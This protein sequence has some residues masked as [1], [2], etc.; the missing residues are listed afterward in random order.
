MSELSCRSGVS[1]TSLGL[2]RSEWL[3]DLFP[4]LGCP[5]TISHGTGTVDSI[6]SETQVAVSHN[7]A[8]H[9]HYNS[10]VAV[11]PTTIGYP[12]AFRRAR[13]TGVPA[14][15][16]Q[17][18]AQ[19]IYITSLFQPVQIVHHS[20]LGTGHRSTLQRALQPRSRYKPR[21]QALAN[22]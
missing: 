15:C 4:L 3:R 7:R 9:L 20:A 10:F 1:C 16:R 12:F 8:T 19:E 6:S 11:I 22:A 5:V 18:W 21:V 13:P 2:F 17:A 14:K